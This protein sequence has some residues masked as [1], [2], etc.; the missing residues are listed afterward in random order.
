ML[1]LNLNFRSDIPLTNQI[2]AQ[3][4]QQ[5]A[6]GALKPG[7]QLP[8]VRALA[9]ELRVN[10]NT[11]ARAY[12]ILDEAGIISTQQGRGTFILEQPPPPISAQIKRQSLSILAQRYLQEA[13]QLGFTREQALEA[14]A[15]SDW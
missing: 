1:K 9:T 4:Q 10:F 8:T 15:Q 6:N 3:I 14:V 11:V 5:L 12:R 2:V 7:D 13:K